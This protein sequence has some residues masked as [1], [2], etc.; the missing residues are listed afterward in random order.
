VSRVFID[1]RGQPIANSR[2][3]FDLVLRPGAQVCIEISNAHPVNYK[4]SLEAIVDTTKPELPDISK[5]TGFLTSLPGY[6]QEDPAKRDRIRGMMQAPKQIEQLPDS[7]LDPKLGPIIRA[8]AVLKEELDSAQSAAAE[9]DT[10]EPLKEIDSGTGGFSKAV[11]R[12]GKLP[13]E[14]FHFNDS[15]LSEHFSEE[16]K[17]ANDWAGTKLERRVFVDA[18]NASSSLLLAARDRLRADYSPS[19]RARQRLCKPVSV[20][21]NTITLAISKSG[22]EGSRDTY[23]KTDKGDG[24]LEVEVESKYQR[25]VVSLDPFTFAAFSHDVP[26]FGIRDDTHRV[27]RTANPTNIR[28][29]LMLSWNPLALDP[30]EKWVVGVGLGAGYSGKDVFADLLGAVTLSYE[31]LV[32]IGIGKGKSSQPESVKGAVINAHIP[33]NFGALKDAVQT[34]TLNSE[35]WYLLISFPG[36]SIGK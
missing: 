3:K 20:G 32:R 21:R 1:D 4:Y 8:L 5:I 30:A 2:K 18:L 22:S 10:P 36:L 31:N 7:V 13:K 14:Q 33:P 6:V 26:V 16:L 28:P 29:G 34:G 17:K 15:K 19:V 23:A 24:L 11:A 25:K 27:E 35:S 9:S 12:I